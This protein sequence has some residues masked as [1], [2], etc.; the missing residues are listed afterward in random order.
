MP[1]NESP[2]GVYA[3][4]LG[5]V[6]ATAA[7]EVVALIT[8]FKAYIVDPDSTSGV[9]PPSPDFAMIPPSVARLLRTELD[10]VSVAIAAAPTA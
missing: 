2:V 3:P 6:D 7:A 9:S 1:V 10:A 8:L 4:V 5:V